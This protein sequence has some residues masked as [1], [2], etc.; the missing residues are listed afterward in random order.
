MNLKKYFCIFW[1]VLLF[2][3]ASCLDSNES[4]VIIPVDA[5]ILSFSIK[6]DSVPV[7]DSVVFYIDQIN[8]VIFN[9]DSIRYGIEVPDTVIVKYTTA[10]AGI[11]NIT[12]AAE[13]DST[14]VTSGDSLD[15][16]KP[17]RFKSY[18][19]DG[20]TI[21]YYT[22][23]I[24]IHQIDPDS[25][26]YIKIASD[27]ACLNYDETG[28]FLFGDVFYTYSKTNSGIELHSSTDAVNWQKETLT[29]L[30]A[31]LN[32]KSVRLF[33]DT[34]VANTPSGKFYTSADA[35]AWTEMSVN[36][37]V[38]AILGTLNKSTTQVEALTCIVKKDDQL[39]FSMTP[40][41]MTWGE[42]R[43]VA[44]NFPISGFS[45]VSYISMMKERVAVV[46]GLSTDGTVQNNTWST[47]DG[48]QWAQLTNSASV[49]PLMTG[50]NAFIYN[51]ILYLLNGELTDNTYNPV[52]YTSKEMGVSWQLA[53][54]K[55]YFPEDYT[56]RQSASLVV[57]KDNFIYIF[58]GK[59]TSVIPDVWKGRLNKL[60]Y[61]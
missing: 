46:G 44:S 34:Y 26:Q 15:I 18:A 5:E 13:G 60:S 45:S 22:A 43:A 7:L 25:M 20:V 58:G 1:S 3:L 42:G 50:P 40:D 23:K 12:N 21:K 6:H 56:L 31:D 59:N 2:P 55:T 49:F 14:W 32:V 30:P 47:M 8:G 27:V 53:K 52:V 51:D 24:N 39:I 41:L 36:N 11:L 17:M 57:D 29:G 16:S 61:K 38:I 10:G 9:K 28:T 4:E 19:Y 35:K 54:S 33:K 48:L 37:P